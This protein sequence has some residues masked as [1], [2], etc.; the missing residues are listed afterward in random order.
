[1]VLKSRS[2]NANKLR[3]STPH[4]ST[5]RERSVVKRQCV[6]RVSPSKTPSEVFVF[7]MS[8]TKSIVT[9]SWPVRRSHR[10]RE[11]FESFRPLSLPAA[12]RHFPTRAS[13]LRR[14]HSQARRAPA[15]QTHT[16]SEHTTRESCALFPAALAA[17]RIA[18]RSPRAA[19]RESA[20]G[21]ALH[22]QPLLRIL[23][24]RPPSAAN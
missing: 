8:I 1:M 6:V 18:R 4:S 24:D 16:K 3:A 9:L 11:R 2:A 10:R 13:F 20:R 14:Y 22:Q 7:P 17:C 15:G 21:P 5:V 19:L 12:R 23:P